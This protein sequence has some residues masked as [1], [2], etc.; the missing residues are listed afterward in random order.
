MHLTM[1]VDEQCSVQDCEDDEKSGLYY[2]LFGADSK[3][4]R[5]CTVGKI[6]Q[7]FER[8]Q[9]PYMVYCRSYTHCYVSNIV[10]Q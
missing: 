3:D 9:K 5:E 7:Y 8:I 2:E 10:H 4:R 6:C 1:Q